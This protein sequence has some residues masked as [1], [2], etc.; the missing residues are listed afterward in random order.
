MSEAIVTQDQIQEIT[1]GPD[2]GKFRITGLPDAPKS[3]PSEVPGTKSGEIPN[4]NSD[5]SV[6][7]D[8]DTEDEA[9]TEAVR[10]TAVAGVSYCSADRHNKKFAVVRDNAIGFDK[11]RCQ[12]AEFKGDAAADRDRQNA[13]QLET[14]RQQPGYTRGRRA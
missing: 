6:G 5:G 1:T 14:D 13:E 2:A 12:P 9:F 3:G 4:Q 10:L 8:F 7:P 11:K